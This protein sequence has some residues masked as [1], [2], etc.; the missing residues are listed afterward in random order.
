MSATATPTLE[1]QVGEFT[2][3]TDALQEGLGTLAKSFNELRSR[4]DQP[5]WPAR[6]DEQGRLTASMEETDEVVDLRFTNDPAKGAVQ[7]S[8]R[9]QKR[10]VR[11]QLKNEG[12]K[13][14]GEF[15]SFSEFTKAGLDGHQ[16]SEFRAKHIRHFGDPSKDGSIAKAVQGMSTQSG[17][18]GGFTVVPEVSNKIFDRVY[19]NDLW[20]RTD[21]YTVNGNSMTFLANAETSRATG[22]RHG[23][24]Q[25]YWVPEGGTI[26]KSK[27][28]MREISLKLVK[29]AVVVYL[30]Q[31]L[32]DDTSQALE[33][34]VTRKV[35]EE[36]NFMIGDSLVNGTGVGMP[37]GMLNAP[38]LVSIAK[39]SGQLAATILPENVVKM[40]SRFYSP[41]LKKAV[42]LHNQDI[43]PQLYL[44]TLGIGTAGTTVYMPPGGVSAS[45]YATLM[46]LPMLPT[47]FNATLGTQGDLM[48]A[49]MSQILSISKGGIAQAVSMHVEFLTDQMALRFTMRL[50][51]RPWDIAPITPYKGTANTQSTFMALD[52][53]A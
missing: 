30:T 45:P 13:P 8:Y 4:L 50:N 35:A 34:Y 26:T 37:L 12:Y 46:G 41:S 2:K 36:F 53:R 1:S 47:E 7:K 51:A 22:S 3:R 31:E 21:N 39:E 49:D 43:G 28:T 18:D 40:Y 14:W 44:M 38:S 10:E 23:G 25:G 17:A 42:W 11:R 52:T 5:Q 24:M 32:L 16:T 29:V 48:L 20:G 19:E 33:Q 9:E 15:K 27:P 6:Y